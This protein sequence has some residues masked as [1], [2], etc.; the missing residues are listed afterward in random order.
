MYFP[1]L[2]DLREDKD[3]K[4]I[5]IAEM[6]GIQQTVYSRYERGFQNIPIEFLI[7]LA[8][9]YNT[10]TDYILGLTNEKKAYPHK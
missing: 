4:Q 7:E 5:E 6:L 8:K 1:R 2:R 3:M 9:F 10:S